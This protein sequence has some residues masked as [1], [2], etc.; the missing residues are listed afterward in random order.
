MLD[1]SL[2]HDD[3][4][5]IKDESDEERVDFISKGSFKQETQKHPLV[6]YSE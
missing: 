3:V 5:P 4:E 2:F 6:W 1:D